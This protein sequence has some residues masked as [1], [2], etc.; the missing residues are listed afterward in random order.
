MAT[1]TIESL[2]KL[3][4]SAVVDAW[5]DYVFYIEF[6][7]FEDYFAAV[8]RNTEPGNVNAPLVFVTE[9]YDNVYPDI[10]TALRWC[11]EQVE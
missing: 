3:P 4:E 6:S 7:G 10:E 11:K 5:N 2:K 1:V 8:Y 9:N